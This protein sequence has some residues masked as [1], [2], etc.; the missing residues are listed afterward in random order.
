MK[1]DPFNLLE[2]SPNWEWQEHQAEDC[3]YNPYEDIWLK[4][5]CNGNWFYSD[6]FAEW[7]EVTT[8]RVLSEIRNIGL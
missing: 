2:L 3:F 1:V 7:F 5:D 4:L 6:N 8:E